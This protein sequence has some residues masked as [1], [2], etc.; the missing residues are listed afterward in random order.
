MRRRIKL[1]L[2]GT[3][4]D[5]ADDGFVL[6]NC[7]LQ[8]LT[9]PASVRNSWT[10]DI[11][12]PRTDT[13][14]RIFGDSFRLDRIA[15]DGGT[16]ADFNAS[17]KLPF[18]IY[19]ETGEILFAGY[20]KLTGVSSE[21]YAVGLYGGLGEFI[22][23]LSYDSNGEKRSL[24]SLDYGV[25]LDF[26]I[27]AAAV[28]DAW[29]RLDG[30]TS[31]PEMWDVINFAPCY[32]GIPEDFQADKALIEP[33]LVGVD[34]ANPPVLDG[35]QCYLT[36]GGGKALLDLGRDMDEW[37]VHDL[38]S[39]LQRPVLN[40]RKLLAAI[41]DPNNNGGWDVDL[42]DLSGV[43]AL[44]TWLTRPLLPSLGTYKQTT[45]GVTI[46]FQQYTAGNV[47]ARFA[48]ADVPAGTDITAK[49]KCDLRLSVAGASPHT[50]LRPY[51]WRNAQS[52]VPS[53]W[54]QQ[55]IFAQAVAYA[56]DNTLV[57]AGPVK[58]FYKSNA[59]ISP[60]ALAEK[61]GYIPKG[62]GE[63]AAPSGDHGYALSGGYY[64]R[65]RDLECEVTGADIARIEME[66][67]I[68]YAHLHGAIVVHSAAGSVLWDDD[69]NQYTGTGATATSGSGTATGTT[70]DTLRSG[71]HITKE[72][73]L[74]TEGTP[75]DYLLALCK[76]C[77]LYIVADAASRSVKILT[78]ATFYDGTT[79][80][81]TGR[82]DRASIKIQPLAFD[83]KWYEFKHESVGG[84]WEQ[85]YE[86]TAGVQY[87]I[88]RVDTGYDF[89][90]NTKDVLAGSVLKSAA[91]VQDRGLWWYYA[92]DADTAWMWFGPTMESGKEFTLW[93][94]DGQAHEAPAP[95]PTDAA[96]P[97]PYNPGWPGYDIDSRAEFR[98]AEDKAV[99]G[100][101]VLLFFNY[102]SAPIDDFNITDDTPAMDSLLGGPCWL[103]ETNNVGL[104]IPNFTRYTHRGQDPETL[105]D[106]GY[107]REVDIQKIN[108]AAG[109][110]LYGLYWQSY[111]HDRLSVH[112][113]VLRCK[114]LLDGWQVGPELLRKF[115]WYGGSLWVLNSI[116]NYS[117][118]TYD[119]AECEFIQVRQI[120]AY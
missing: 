71:A 118:T 112:G 85:E 59:D 97:I 54:E 101:D 74:S 64:F 49:V 105:L 30:D 14:D 100:A 80:D 12:L 99:D 38:R 56:S 119:P 51:H 62:D 88:Q 52:Y 103:V 26:D 78:R 5:L 17:R 35:E 104:E 16:G 86:K 63:F 29:A 47:I 43:A 9:N 93:D 113:K 37:Q 28:A 73:L 2:D 67:Y 6:L 61:V 25:D 91:A 90:A 66:V 82:V 55:I 44:D 46:S 81:L 13:N 8:N 76:M 20:A 68:Y 15:G 75:A 98:D 89:D 87:G 48:L 109:D 32:N 23:A 84:R 96:T 4:A 40:V 42:S 69:G 108:Y 27:T 95:S 77:G 70:A 72:M 114:V 36:K 106:F 92:Y 21:G 39:Y 33:E 45:G 53:G 94:A 65:Q 1:Y 10:Q 22:Y 34:T 19:T 116:S 115:F 18:S 79:L 107:P 7:A 110:T 41:A 3:R 117:L 120:S 111:I 83:A 57:A 50:P 102:V 11:V 24:A 58:S 60:S 31:K